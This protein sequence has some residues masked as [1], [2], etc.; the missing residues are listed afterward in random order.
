M[1]DKSCSVTRYI[2]PTGCPRRCCS[3]PQPP[4]PSTMGRHRLTPDANHPSDEKK[5][6]G[7]NGTGQQK[8][9]T[10]VTP[11]QA[12]KI[13]VPTEIGESCASAQT[14]CTGEIPNWVDGPTKQQIHGSTHNRLRR[15]NPNRAHGPKPGIR[16][17]P[18]RV[19]A[20]TQN[21]YIGQPS[22]SV[23]LNR[24]HRSTRVHGSTKTEYTGR[25]KPGTRVHPYRVHRSCQTGYRGQPKSGTRVNP[26]RVHWP[27]QIGH[28][29]QPKAVEL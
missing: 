13:C 1:I 21:R 27:T 20:S 11:N 2:P 26:N 28:T 8:P 19:H 22:T 3:P 14:G 24:V 7:S 29:D 4:S 10:W 23:N 16:V 18:H 12:R 15:S 5:A 9:G 25:P 6:G 17:N